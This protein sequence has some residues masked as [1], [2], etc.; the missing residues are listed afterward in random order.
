MGDL[1][2]ASTCWGHAKFHQYLSHQIDGGVCN[3][4]IWTLYRVALGGLDHCPELLEI[5]LCILILPAQNV[6]LAE[7]IQ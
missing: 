2:F 3:R 5:G 1:D 6:S 4:E 7:V